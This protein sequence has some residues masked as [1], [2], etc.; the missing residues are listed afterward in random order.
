MKTFSKFITVALIIM[1]L[2][3]SVTAILGGIALTIGFGAPPLDMLQGSLFNNWI[4]PGLA[5][6]LIVGGSALFAAILLLR[7][8]KYALLAS[9]TAGT[10]IMF[11]EFVEALTIGSPAGVAFTLQ[12]IY[13][14]VGTLIIVL[15]MG[16]WFLELRAESQ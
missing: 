5:L 1:T 4:I 7:K 8:S 13:F 10:I 15:A 11:F 6:M 16:A 12:V 3:L 2:F 14:G 9:T